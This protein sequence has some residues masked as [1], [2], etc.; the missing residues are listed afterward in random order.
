MEKKGDVL[1]QLAIIAD[2]IEK[3]NFNSKNNNLIFTLEDKDFDEVYQYFEK[4]YSNRTEKV[5][6][7]FTITIETVSIVFNRN[8]V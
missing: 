2:L 5:K 6:N 7:T 3:I 1:N 8:N 4:K